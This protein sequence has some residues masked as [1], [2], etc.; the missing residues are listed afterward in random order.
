MPSRHRFITIHGH[1]YQPPRENPWLEAV[2]TQD[3]AFPWHDWNERITGECYEPNATARILDDDD[4]IR[5]IVNNYSLISFNFGPTLLSWLEDS[6]PETYAAVIEADRLSRERYGGHGCAIAQ[7]YNHT[8][9]PLASERD[10][11]TQVRWGVR[12]FEWRFGRKPEGMWLPETAVDVPSLEA[13]AAEE[14]AFTIL[15]P[16]QA[17][18]W[19]P[20]GTSEWQTANGHLDPTRPYVCRL[21]SGK[22]IAIFFYDGPISRAVAFEQ[23]LA[24]GENLAQ[25]LTGAFRETRSHP[26]VVSIATDGETYG[27]H[28]RYGE[29]AL[30]FALQLIEEQGHARLT[31]Y[32]EHLQK[33]P[34]A[35]EVEIAERTA[36]SCSHGVERWQSDCGCHTGA[37]PGWNQ[38]WRG[39]LRSALDWLAGEAARIFES[40]GARVLRN[41]WAARDAYI[42]VILDRS[43][44]SIDRF[45]AAHALPGAAVSPVL[46]LL[47]MQRNAMLMYTSCGWFFNDVS[48]IETGQVLNYAARVIQ[49]AE[50]TGGVALDEEFADRLE[51]S[52][53]NVPERGTARRIYEEEVIPSRLDLARVA[54]H[55]AVLS[56]FDT[57]DDEERLYCYEVVRHGF[58]IHKA[59]RTRLA[60]GSITVR[61]LITCEIASFELAALHLGETELAGG[62]RA[63]HTGSDY[64]EVRTAL[65]TAM[66]P[67]GI[68]AVIRLLDLKFSERPLS[69]QSLFKDEQ[70]R[71]ME[72]LIVST[73]EEAESAFR[74]LHE[75]Y[76]PLMR[77]HARLGIPAPKVLHTAAEFDLN[78]QL[79][80][81]LRDDSPSI[82]EI[83]SRLREATVEG[84]T[85]DETTLLAFRDAIEE[86]SIQFRERPED[87]DRLEA[88]EALVGI[89]HGAEL[90]VDLRRAQNR[91]YRMRRTVRPAIEA[92]SGNGHAMRRWL[93]LFDSLGA[94][95]RIAIE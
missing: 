51:P 81:L 76:D 88:L 41:P 21:P 70:R 65:A 31:N 11:K 68:P 30:T 26:Q 59:G 40:E 9:L 64:E 71:I 69:I 14:I 92:S 58:E 42:D 95:L 45:M 61:S 49:L 34:P 22:S 17:L 38:T 57:F 47:E 36:W 19:R 83:E 48:G 24:R 91:Y 50:R 94:D 74:Q 16:G 8:I 73:L 5:R 67:G 1:F 78:Q 7:A 87:L 62:I 10:R 54:A 20:I 90:A 66:Q 37:S 2:E 33:F 13:L 75:R 60:I 32:A 39:P 80:R 12:D 4:R 15:E 3:S 44:D 43:D 79:R 28:H 55:Y 52:V 46:E 63:V 6:A 77:L 56:L 18:R 29:M 85:L 93:E 53:S 82:A 86:A 72:R 84:V 25:R 89:V 35:Y 27:H 23:L